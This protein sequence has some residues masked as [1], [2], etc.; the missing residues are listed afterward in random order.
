MPASLNPASGHKTS[1]TAPLLLQG[2]FRYPVLVRF[3]TLN[4]AG[5]NT[6]SYALDEISAV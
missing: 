6:N 3:D 4:Y 2:S 1:L 5:V